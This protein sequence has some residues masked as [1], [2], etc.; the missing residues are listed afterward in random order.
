MNERI[1]YAN[2]WE[3]ADLLLTSANLPPNGNILSIASGG[4]NS[5]ALLSTAP[6][7]LYAVDTNV[8]QLHLC[9][10]K[11]AAFSELKYDETLAL[12]WG[13]PQ[14]KD[15]FEILKKQLSPPCKKYWETNE[16]SIQSGVINE[17]KFEQYFRFFRKRVMPFI[18]SKKTINELLSPKTEQEQTNFYHQKWNT[19]RWKFLFKLFFSKFVLGRFGR[20]KAYLN[21]VEIPV[22]AFIFEQAAQH[23]QSKDCQSNYFLHYIFTGEFKPE[24]PFYL[25]EENYQNIKQNL[26]ALTLKQGL[27]QDFINPETA[28][29]YC[30]FSNIFEYMNKEEFANFH[31][32]LEQYLPN[33]AIIGYWN[34]MVD[35]VF[36]TS[37]PQTFSLY[38]KPQKQP[39]DKGFFYKRFV[40]EIKNER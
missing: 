40:T 17:G 38:N 34:L 35:R 30:N 10:L 23:L 36:S 33:K 5:F 15:F 21:Q 16:S 9:E 12:F 13:T 6:K 18:H 22:A 20:T 32:L 37:F 11:A 28:F 2:C 25:R 19:I 27:V 31:Q 24:L 14:A 3:D 39:T 4:D 1:K 8:A 7:M 26:A 29:N